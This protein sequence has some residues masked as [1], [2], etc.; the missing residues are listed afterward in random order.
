MCFI[1]AVF[2]EKEDRF[3]WGHQCHCAKR[4]RGHRA[5]WVVSLTKVGHAQ[6]A[7][8]EGRG[9]EGFGGRSQAIHL[10]EGGSLFDR[11]A[12]RQPSEEHS[13]FV[14]FWESEEKSQRRLGL[15][16]FC[17]SLAYFCFTSGTICDRYPPSCKRIINPALM[18]PPDHERNAHHEIRMEN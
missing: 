4:L 3:S 8:E 7:A 13:E 10:E 17:G 1:T 16:L 2:Y 12:D 15:F 6:S 5:C 9:S 11:Q 14:L 18:F